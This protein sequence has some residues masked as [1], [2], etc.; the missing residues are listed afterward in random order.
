MFL[1]DWQTIATDDAL[2]RLRNLA[3]SGD[4]PSN[5]ALRPIV[6]AVLASAGGLP[7]SP[8][9]WS[10]AEC[11]SA[12]VRLLH[13]ATGAI[14][15]R[16]YGARSAL[17]G[18]DLAA[19][20]AGLDRLLTLKERV[21]VN[22]A[23]EAAL[24]PLPVL[25][26]VTAG[27]SIESRRREG[28]FGAPA[29]IAERVV[30]VNTSGA[31]RLSLMLDFSEHA[32]SASYDGDFDADFGRLLKRQSAGD[33][34]GRL[35]D[36]LETLASFTASEPHPFTRLGKQRADLPQPADSL[37]ADAPAKSVEILEDE[38]YL[39]RIE[40]LLGGATKSIDVAMFFMSLTSAQ[41]P[42][43]RLLK[44]LA[45]AHD[46]GRTV[47]VLLD[48]D[49]DDD[50]YGSRTINAPAITFLKNS[51]VPVRTDT[52]D[53]L[54]HSKFVVIDG[55]QAVVGS[56]NWTS[57]SYFRYHDTSLAIDSEGFAGA[58][59]ARFDKLW[60]AGTEP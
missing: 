32:V 41:H 29:D 50:P 37:P 16:R 20:G 12:C 39:P 6:S 58:L 1:V 23:S 2:D 27:R 60:Q 31:E 47:R 45:D 36:A 28:A 40:A 25:G 8:S 57:G 53:N 9:E 56:H 19:G 22:R 17:P 44:Q 18:C 43:N 38:S 15:R 49:S 48:R 59:K 7:V 55:A 5:Q 30:G 51:G 42:T 24:E 10:K 26:P 34:A 11:T 3:G 35:L 33:A 4:Q 13:E 54:L 46:N 21:P 52:T 14:L